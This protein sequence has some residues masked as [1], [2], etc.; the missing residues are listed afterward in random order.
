[1]DCPIC[2]SPQ[3]DIGR[4]M[5]FDNNIIHKVG[6]DDCGSTWDEWYVLTFDYYD[7]TKDT[8][9]SIDDHIKKSEVE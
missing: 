7:I 2:E 5:Y 8:R 3:V 9:E 1:M 4:T 6:C